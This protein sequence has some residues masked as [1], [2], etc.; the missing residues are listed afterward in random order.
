MG[1]STRRHALVLA[2]S[3]ALLYGSTYQQFRF[4]TLEAPGGATDALHYV[5]MARGEVEVD[6][7]N[8]YHY[9]WV[10]PAAARFIQPSLDRVMPD[11]DLAMRLSFY[12]VNFAFTIAACLT[13]FALLQVLGY[14]TLL[15]LLGIA[16]FA[17][18]RTTVLT[19][20]TPMVDAIYYLAIAVVVFLTVTRRTIALALSLP[21][22]ILSKETILPFLL[23]PA[24]TELRRS[25]VYWAGLTAAV[26]SHVVSTRVIDATHLTAGPTMV[27][28]AAE[29]WADLR[30]SL[31]RVTTLEGLHDLQSGF[32]LLIPLAIM[33][34]WLNSR[35]RYRDIPLVVVAV[36]PI[37]AGLALLSGNMGRMFFAAFPA[38]IAY[39]LV[40]VEH[41]ARQGEAR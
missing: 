31:S 10:T 9:R 19:T 32:S 7:P 12:L 15:S 23:L 37:A 4:F 39:A 18:S 27:E 17:T 33:G 5:L 36:V 14:P 22:L 11:R 25:P 16:F 35:Y 13:L 24:L 1:S 40:A 38:V 6:S 34:M 28:F 29:H 41:V 3:I 30:L 2:V 8:R 20:A 21:L 26:F